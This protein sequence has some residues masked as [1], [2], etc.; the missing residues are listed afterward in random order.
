VPDAYRFSKSVRS[1]AARNENGRNLAGVPLALEHPHGAGVMG[2]YA[3][4]ND[5]DGRVR[6]GVSGNSGQSNESQIRN[7]EL[8]RMAAFRIRETA[9]RIMTLANNARDEQL[10]AELI[11]ACDRL[12]DEERRLLARADKTTDS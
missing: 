10:R 5:G 6:G 4:G 9:N 11:A 7:D 1:P 12:L 2:R 8:F 3:M